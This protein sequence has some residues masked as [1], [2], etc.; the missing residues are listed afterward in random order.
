MAVLAADGLAS[1]ERVEIQR[2]RLDE[3]VRRAV[4]DG[5]NP[6]HARASADAPFT[7]DRLPEP[8][9]RPDIVVVK[10]PGEFDYSV[11]RG[12]NRPD[13]L[14]DLDDRVGGAPPDL[15]EGVLEVPDDVS[16]TAKLVARVLALKASHRLLSGD[17][18]KFAFT[19]AAGRDLIR[20]ELKK[21][22]D[23]HRNRRTIGRAL[24][25]LCDRGAI[26]IVGQLDDWYDHNEQRAKF[27]A[28]VYALNVQTRKLGTLRARARDHLA[29]WTATRATASRGAAGSVRGQG[30][31]A[32]ALEGVL[33]HAKVGNRNSGGHWLTMR[34]RESGLDQATTTSWMDRYR[35][36]L[37]AKKMADG[38]TEREAAATVRSAYRRS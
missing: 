33:R 8:T 28:Y 36:A 3:A 27:G 16:P 6:F 25:E 30:C 1:L 15:E 35:E 29:Q 38:Y 32:G 10:A 26:K 20:H 21:V 18:T 2:L 12:G 13:W 9:V 4:R 31:L 14:R 24:R 11:T 23:V 7:L 22:Y 34:C 37:A 19:I 17:S 5:D